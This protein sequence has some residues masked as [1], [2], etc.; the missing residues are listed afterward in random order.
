M[1]GN[2]PKPLLF[3]AALLTSIPAK[4][5]RDLRRGPRYLGED[6]LKKKVKTAAVITRLKPCSFFTCSKMSGSHTHNVAGTC[7]DPLASQAGV[8]L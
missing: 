6:S 1:S 4:V 5:A 7:K 2:D 3:I 8:I